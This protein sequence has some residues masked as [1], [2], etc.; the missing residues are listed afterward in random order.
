MARQRPIEVRIQEKRDELKRLQTVQSIAKLRLQLR[1]PKKR[2]K[3]T[4]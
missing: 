1:N 2:K 3:R 4:T